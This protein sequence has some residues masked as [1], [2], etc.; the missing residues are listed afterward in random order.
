MVFD[1]EE[2]ESSANSGVKLFADLCH[3]VFSG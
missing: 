3:R 2:W 1:V